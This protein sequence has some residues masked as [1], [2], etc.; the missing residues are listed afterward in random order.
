MRNNVLLGPDF[1]SL[2]RDKKHSIDNNFVF[3]SS[4]ATITTDA[5]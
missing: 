3:Y 4:E 2:D 1:S 5:G